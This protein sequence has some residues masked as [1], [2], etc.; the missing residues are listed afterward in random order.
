MVI[1]AA[2]AAVE[3]ILGFASWLGLSAPF[4][5]KKQHEPDPVEGVVGVGEEIITSGL[6]SEY[7]LINSH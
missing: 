1:A 7:K 5:G 2:D 3:V 6:I 4:V